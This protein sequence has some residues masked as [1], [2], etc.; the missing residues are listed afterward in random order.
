MISAG[1]WHQESLDS[2]SETKNKNQSIL[3]KKRIERKKGKWWPFC[4]R[5]TEKYRDADF[6]TAETDGS[7]RNCSLPSNFRRWSFVYPPSDQSKYETGYRGWKTL[8]CIQNLQLKV[9]N[10]ANIYPLEQWLIRP[11][12]NSS[13]HFVNST[14]HMPRDWWKCQMCTGFCVWKG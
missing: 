9:V 6:S 4:G 10:L 13:L 3:T 8:G 2:R 1:S 14:A 12:I 11:L 7:R 5:S